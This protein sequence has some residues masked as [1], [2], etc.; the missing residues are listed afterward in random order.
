MII[1]LIRRV[2]TRKTEYFEIIG[3]SRRFLFSRKG[4]FRHFSVNFPTN[5]SS[6][7]A[8]ARLDPT[9]FRITIHYSTT[10]PH[11]L[12][13]KL[14]DSTFF[15]FL[16]TCLPSSVL[17]FPSSVLFNLRQYCVFLRKYSV[18]LRQYSVH[19]R[20]Y[21]VFLPPVRC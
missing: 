9:S 4:V 20:Q 1:E 11:S 18:H 10:A 2:P 8:P 15:S 16:S 5:E 12:Y 6:K 21:S 7:A 14:S 17:C 3:I 19:L 13:V